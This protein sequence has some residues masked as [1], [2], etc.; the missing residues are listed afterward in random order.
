MYR[1]ILT[2]VVGLGVLCTLNAQ[3]FKKS[4]SAAGSE[5][6]VVFQ[7]ENATIFIEGYNGNELLIEADGTYEV[8]ERAKGLRPLYNG[9]TDNTGIGL[10]VTES[11][12]VM[13]IKKASS[14]DGEYRIRVPAGANIMIEEIG[15]MSDEFKLSNLSGEIEIRSNGSD[16]MLDKVTGP[17]VAN[18]TS[19]DITILFAE[20]NQQQPTSISAVSGFIDITLPAA[21]KATFDLNSV[22]GEIFTDLDIKMPKAQEGMTMIGGRKINGTLN[23]GGVEMSLRAISGDIYLR[24]KG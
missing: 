6:K 10:E 24:K 1:V 14:K 16:I 17:V 9:A 18:S 11:N 2:L 20:I 12:N 5:K 19:G 7:V 23:G 8:P 15:W 13:T 21:S 4:F 22:S 3:Q